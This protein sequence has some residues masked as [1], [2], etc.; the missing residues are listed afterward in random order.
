MMLYVLYNSARILTV[1]VLRRTLY[2]Q[3]TGAC[4]WGAA[5]TALPCKAAA[6]TVGFI[7]MEM[8]F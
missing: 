1:S 4:Q 6:C 5:V 3:G 7:S 2:M 8:Q